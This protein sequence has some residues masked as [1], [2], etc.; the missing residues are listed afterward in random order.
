MNQ[1]RIKKKLR[2]REGYARADE[3]TAS[4]VD[5]SRADG[6]CV[7]VTFREELLSIASHWSGA[8]I[9]A[10]FDEGDGVVSFVLMLAS[11]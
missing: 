10:G 2:R 6:E 5:L 8:D 3:D 1:N 4:M 7:R 11:M 9:S